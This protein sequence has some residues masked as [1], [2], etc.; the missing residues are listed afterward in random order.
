[1]LALLTLLAMTSPGEAHRLTQSSGGGVMIPSLY[2]GQMEVISRHYDEILR[3]AQ[4]HRPASEDF[5]RIE[6]Y[7]IIQ[8]AWCGWGL[9][10]GAITDENSP[11][12]ECSHAYLAAARELLSQ[13]RA[14]PAA[15]AEVIS[16]ANAVDQEMLLAGAVVCGYSGESFDTADHITPHMSLLFFHWPTLIALAGAIAVAVAL[17]AVIVL[18]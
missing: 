2:H 18:A 10:P 1:M 9:M 4:L 12:N 11:F 3:L 13:L 14:D 15:S 7:A 6:N 16:L 8:K 17:S 5:R